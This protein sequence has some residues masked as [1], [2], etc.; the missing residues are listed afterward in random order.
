MRKVRGIVSQQTPHRCV[1]ESSK[2][3]LSGGAVLGVLCDITGVLAESSS[4]R[5]NLCNKY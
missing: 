4:V 2:M 1:G 5:D 3:S